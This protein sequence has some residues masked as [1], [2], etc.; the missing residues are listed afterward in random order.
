MG[1]KRSRGLN[2]RQFLATSAAAIV[3]VAAVHGSE[4]AGTPN[5]GTQSGTS[6]LGPDVSYVAGGVDRV[7]M[8]DSVDLETASGPVRAQFR[9]ASQVD[10][11]NRD[12][13]HGLQAFEAGERVTMRI[14]S[15]EPATL[16]TRYGYA[17]GRVVSRTATH[18]TTS[19]GRVMRI[20]ANT[21]VRH[22]SAPMV[23]APASSVVLGA[24]VSVTTRYDPLLGEHVARLVYVSG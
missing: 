11:F 10:R 6:S 12:G 4:A 17:E 13:T 20:P 19:D 14:D 22:A 9:D 24:V 5:A 15:G 8:P 2:R 21:L 18:L 16:E 3:G 23:T 1:K 7:L